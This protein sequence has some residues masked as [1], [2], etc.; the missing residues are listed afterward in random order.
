MF[1]LGE[2]I[3]ESWTYRRLSYFFKKIIFK[4]WPGGG[5]ARL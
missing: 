3:A 1:N 2:S 5:G 4:I